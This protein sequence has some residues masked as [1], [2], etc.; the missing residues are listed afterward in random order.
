MEAN[1]AGTS[2]LTTDKLGSFRIG[3][4]LVDFEGEKTSPGS[5]ATSGYDDDGV[6]TGQWPLIKGGVF[7][8]YQTTRDQAQLIGKKA[9]RGT[10]LAQSWAD[11]PFQRMPNVNLLPGK[12]PLSEAQLIAD[13]ERGIFIKG[14]GSYS[15]DHQRYNFQFGGQTFHEIKK[16]KIVGMLRD[17]AYQARTPDFWK[18]C[19]AICDQSV[20]A[21]NGSF[22]DGKGEPSQ[23]NAVSH[24]CATSRFR[25]VNVLNTGKQV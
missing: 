13:T 4:D 7:V 1:Y 9:S 23:S 22:N 18:S 8:D 12:K 24:G 15:I 3:S 19:D 17:G 21:V 5:L 6:K 2:F 20:Y 25:Q 11:V 16:G 10:C 14:R